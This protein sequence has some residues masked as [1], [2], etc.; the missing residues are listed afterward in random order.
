MFYSIP[1]S[2]CTPQ[3]N[4]RTKN[5]PTMPRSTNVPPDT[6]T[7]LRKNSL[8]W[9]SVHQQVQSC[10]EYSCF[11][12]TTSFDVLCA[13]MCFESKRDQSLNSQLD[14]NALKVITS[15]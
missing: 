12:A 10:P 9:R 5:A 7:L 13:H 1:G 2:W 6:T 3:T 14:K 4:T 11:N 15:L 8:W